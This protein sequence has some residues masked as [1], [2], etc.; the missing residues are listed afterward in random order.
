MSDIVKKKISSCIKKGLLKRVEYFFC[1]TSKYNIYILTSA[2]ASKLNSI[3]IDDGA[4]AEIQQALSQDLEVTVHESPISVNGW[5]GSGYS[6]IDSG[7]GVGAYKISGGASGGSLELGPEQIILALGGAMEVAL[8]TLM[9]L[10]VTKANAGGV[11]PASVA[12]DALSGFLVARG[13]SGGEIFAS[14][15]LS[16]L[17]GLIM[18][19]LIDLLFLG[20]VGA[21]LAT[22]KAALVTKFVGMVTTTLSA[23]HFFT[24]DR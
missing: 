21:G 8:D 6:I 22:A 18:V 14:I 16:I 24:T 9:S 7:M 23:A 2:N 4:R 10:L 15:V 3:T 11:Q 12:A 17:A 19:A 13:T 20:L 5:S 1:D